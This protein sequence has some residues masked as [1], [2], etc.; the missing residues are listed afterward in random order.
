[1]NPFDFITGFGGGLIGY[2]VVLVLLLLCGLGVPVPED[3]ILVSG[4]Y[5]A[6]AGEH[7][8]W[9][10]ML[11]G[12]V[13]IIA[14]DSIIFGLGRKMGVARVEKSFLRRFLTP[15][16]LA[17]VDRL[18]RKHGQKILVAARFTPGL[19]AVTFFTAGAIGVPYWR[20]FTYDGL[21]ALVS[22]PLWV[23]LGFR[24]GGEVIETAKKW[25]AYIFGGLIAVFVIWYLI[26]RWRES[27]KQAPAE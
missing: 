22:A 23:Y 17:R 15:E 12:L 16:R 3:V 14:G 13:G 11:T 21:A 18:F 20:F 1:M 2:V 25:Q 7:A 6:A 5:V 9:P 8:V 4:G 24:Y 26:S 10:M 19:R 27:R